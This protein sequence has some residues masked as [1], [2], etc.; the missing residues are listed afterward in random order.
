MRREGAILER[1]R[2]EDVVAAVDRY[3]DIR[4]AGPG[5]AGDA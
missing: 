3:Y 5:A 1:R 4:R 2:F